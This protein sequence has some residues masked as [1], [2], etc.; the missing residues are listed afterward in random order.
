MIDIKIT[1]DFNSDKFEKELLKEIKKKTIDE[2]KSRLRK[3]GMTFNE[4][5]QI[6][7]EF[8]KTSK[9]CYVDVFGNTD[10]IDSKVKS[11]LD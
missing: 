10:E 7:F 6:T 9:E 3:G 2:I 8:V 4:M 1:S 11:I 5:R